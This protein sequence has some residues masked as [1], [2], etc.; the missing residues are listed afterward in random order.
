MSPEAQMLFNIVAGVAG[1]LGSFVLKSQWD[2]IK[3]G[4]KDRENLAKKIA[5]IEVLV[6][7]DYV[8]KADVDKLGDAIFR[9][10]DN[11]E[12]KLDRKADK[13]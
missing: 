12:N 9:K 11:I 10:L 7:G 8:K 2:A 4:Q 1:A 5:E 3:D 6:A 13:P